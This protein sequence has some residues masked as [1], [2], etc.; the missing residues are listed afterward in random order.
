MA[1]SFLLTS[2]GNPGNLNPCL[3][4]AR[5]LRQRGH[6]VRILDEVAH[7]E[8]ARKAGFDAI[9]WRRPAPLTPPDTSSEEPHWAEFRAVFGQVLFGH[10]IDYAADTMDALRSEPADA[11]LTNDLV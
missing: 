5:R 1:L 9:A 11:I 2:W 7:Q 4:A 10:A 6:R 3:T 8:E